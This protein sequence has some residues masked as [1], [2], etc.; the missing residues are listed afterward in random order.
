MFRE[1][2]FVRASAGLRKS[3]VTKQTKGLFYGIGAG[4]LDQ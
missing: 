1:E 2:R 3:R 4:F